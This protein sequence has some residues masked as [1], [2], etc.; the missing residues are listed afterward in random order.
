MK[1]LLLSAS[2]V[3]LMFSCQ[4]DDTNSDSTNVAALEIS[5]K[6][7][8]ATQDMLELQLKNDPTLAKKM[9]EMEEDKMNDV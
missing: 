1:K 6:R 3:F 4:N 2:I 5:A 8:C 9:Q 7:S